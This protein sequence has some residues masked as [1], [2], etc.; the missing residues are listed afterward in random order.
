[1]FR[2]FIAAAFLLLSQGVYAQFA[3]TGIIRDAKN[4]QPLVGA[5]IETEAVKRFAVSDELGHFNLGQFAAG[6]YVL[7]IRFL[8]YAEKVENVHAEN[9][10]KLD[11]KLEETYQMTDEVVVY[12]TRANDKTPTTYTNINQQSIQKQ[13]FG[14]DLPMVLNWTPSLV[15]TSD[16]GA[17]VGYTGIRIRG[18]DATRVNVTINGIPYND[19]ESQG[20]YWVDIPDVA[21]STK[22]IQIQRGVG[23]STNGGSAFG[24]SVNLQTSSLVSNPY[25]EL[26]VSGGSFNTQRYTLKTG[27]GLI[28]NHWAFDMKL[29]KI[30]SDGYVDRASSNLD[31]Y[32]LSGGYFG[33]KTV[34]KAITFGGHEKTYQSWNGISP[35]IMKVNRRFNSTGALYDAAGNVTGYYDNQ[36]DNYRQDH[37]QLHFTHQ[38]NSYWN[39]NVSLHY[40]YGRGYY[41]EYHQG[42][43]LYYFAL[44]NV[45]IGDSTI[46][47]TDAIV[48]KWLDNKF[49]GTTFSLNYEKEKIHFT[50]GGAWNQYAN[51]KHFG[52]LMWM[53]VATVPIRYRYYNGDAQ[54]NDFNIYGK[55]NYDITEALNAFVDIQYRYVDYKTSGIEDGQVPYNVNDK[56]N[57]FNPKAGLSYSLSKNDILYSS[58]AIA[59]RE[60][61][62]TDYLG[63]D[64]KPKS[65]HLGN[66]EAGWRRSASNYNIEVNYYLMNYTNQLVLTGQINNVGSPI[67]ANVGKSYRTGIEVA[68][69]VRLLDKLS[70]N[71]NVTKSV[72]KNVDYAYNDAD[73]TAKKNTTI[74]LSP[75]WIAGSQLTWNAF[76]NFQGTLLTKYVGKQYLDNTQNESLTLPHYTINDIRLMYTLHPKGVKE[77]GLSVLLNNIF[78]VDYASNG[79]SYGGTPYYYPQA[80][81]NFLAM[82]TLKF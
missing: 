40:T 42:D 5:T 28:N 67:R 68:G 23:T 24:A 52:Q 50:L 47:A 34:I 78:G 4:N 64:V 26:Y 43:S 77:I 27:T 48:R 44:P 3:I 74:I 9:N 79:Y 1:M 25:T 22:S 35:D 18:S 76:K 63:N 49:Y 13:N 14:Q 72:N 56:F 37:Y 82:V 75:S 46:K 39:A 61:N 7:H 38:V 32:Y 19:S 8:G 10:M 31:S 51:A 58:Y 66:L 15:T 55:L 65:E 36:I 17:G 45:V 6:D 16:A 71:L 73:V 2:L 12:A 54:K 29:S 70:W 69:T 41:E 33:K 59:N 30:K 81:R 20:T 53:Q 21:S 57:F 62:R 11:I 80:G 60:P